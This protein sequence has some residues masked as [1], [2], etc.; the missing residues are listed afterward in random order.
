MKRHQQFLFPFLI[1]LSW[2]YGIVIFLRN[3]LYDLGW[4]KGAIINKPIIS[5]GNI[6]SGGTGKT[7]MVIYMSQLLQKKGKKPGIISRGYGRKSQGLQVVHDGTKLIAEVNVAGDEPYLMAK[8]LENVPIVVSENRINGIKKLIDNYLVDIIIMDDGFQHMKVKRD[9]DIVTV[10][11]NEK[12]NNY[13]LLPWGNLREPIKNIK[14]A[15]LVIYTKTNNHILPDIHPFIFRHLRSKH[16]TSIL[17]PVLMKYKNSSY[18]KITTP[19]EPMFAFCGIADPLSFRS[20]AEELS[21][22]IKCCQFFKDHQD[23][24]ASVIKKL[25]DE[26]SLN[27]I[28]SVVTT[29]KDVV[30]LPTSFLSEFDIY[31]IKINF[32]FG[33]DV[34]FLSELES[35]M[36]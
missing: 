5:I 11:A 32:K 10:S 16:L 30:K 6:T 9:L 4:I 36:I 26:I 33:N 28:T 1:P 21:L 22:Q 24:N 3:K 27:K 17:K 31:I 15:N 7:P 14:R 29:E 19:T 2:I 25:S 35:A 20:S 8:M 18:K 23:Y 13:R 34:A 12:E